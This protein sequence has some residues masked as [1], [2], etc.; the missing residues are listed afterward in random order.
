MTSIQN[1]SW[2]A[3]LSTSRRKSRAL[4]SAPATTSG[5]RPAAAGPTSITIG[6]A[7]SRRSEYSWSAT[8][9]SQA[10]LPGRCCERVPHGDRL[11]GVLTT[12]GRG[13]RRSCDRLL[14]H[15][16]CLAQ[17]ILDRRDLVVVTN[18]LRLA[19]LLTPAF[20]AASSTVPQVLPP[21]R[22]QVEHHIRRRLRRDQTTIDDLWVRVVAGQMVGRVGLEPTT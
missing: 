6:G 15:D 21:P 9:V 11:V 4:A 7:R 12:D 3:K 22:Q 10:I 14:D 20:G 19:T 18:G 5:N 8:C 1:E 17:E 2:M 13:W 16:V